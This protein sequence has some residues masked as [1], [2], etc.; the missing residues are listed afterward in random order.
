MG[1][2]SSILPIFNPALASALSALW[3][4]G[5]GVLVLDPPVAL[6]LMCNALTPSSLT[7]AATSCAASMAAYGEDSSR[8]ALTFIPPVTRHSVSF[9]DRSVTCTKV[10]LN[11]AKI[12]ATPQ[13]SS[14]SL[15]RNAR[16]VCQTAGRRRPR[17]TRT[18]RATRTNRLILLSNKEKRGKQ[19]GSGAVE[20]RPA[21]KFRR[22]FSPNPESPLSPHTYL[23]AGPSLTFSTS[24]RTFG[25]ILVH[26]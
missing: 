22:H 21:W 9:P 6:S 23:V 15:S 12:C 20:R 5:P 3:A 17:T 11:E 25:A 16:G 13:T 26:K 2:T 8:S 10:S 19:T 18:T 1:V 4:P 24:L 7:L 14:P